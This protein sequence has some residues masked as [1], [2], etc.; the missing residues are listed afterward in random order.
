MPKLASVC[1]RLASGAGA[2]TVI[3]VSAP[4]QSVNYIGGLQYASGDFIFT[5]RTWSAYLSNGLSWSTGLLRASAS[6]PLVMQSSGW[7]QYS[8]AGMMVPSGGISGSRSGGDSGMETMRS[9]MH[10]GSMTPSKGMPF[11]RVGVGDPIGR[12]E[13]AVLRTAGERAA[14]KLVGA[15]KAPLADVGRGFGTGEWDIGTGASGLLRI[16]GATVLAE[17][18]YW[19]LGRPPGTALRNAMAYALSIGRPLSRSRWSVLAGVSGASSLWDGLIGPAQAGL[20]FGYRLE[21]GG[22]VFATAAAGLTR[23]APAISTGLGWRLPIGKE[24]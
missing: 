20:G 13:V 10:L 11:S 15:T 4:A 8:G 18:M 24:R 22:T 9:G 6:I 23:T 5:E 14:V 16:R 7:L 12:I 3:S 1:R 21:S 17:A 19:K 2:L